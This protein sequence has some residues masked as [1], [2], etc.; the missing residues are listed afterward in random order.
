MRNP[1]E[2]PTVRP[3][4]NWLC[5]SLSIAPASKSCAAPDAAGTD[6][7]ECDFGHPMMET[8]FIFIA[9]RHAAKDGLPHFRDEADQKPG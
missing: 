2:E 6:D 3:N 9:D 5:A 8:G 7:R 4:L 1:V